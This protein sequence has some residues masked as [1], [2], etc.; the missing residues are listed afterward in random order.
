MGIAVD[1]LVLVDTVQDVIKSKI[2]RKFK[3]HESVFD[4]EPSFW[5]TENK[6][7]IENQLRKQ[8]NALK[9]TTQ[10]YLGI[11][12]A[13]I[14]NGVF[15]ELSGKWCTPSL[16]GASPDPVDVYLFQELVTTFLPGIESRKVIRVPQFVPF[17][18]EQQLK[19]S[20]VCICH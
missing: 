3:D 17:E 8:P 5:T 10:A 7:S 19:T 15:R 13:Q 18:I 16:V 9:V 12:A 6:K 1:T 11:Q 14:T 2:K 20:S 4:F